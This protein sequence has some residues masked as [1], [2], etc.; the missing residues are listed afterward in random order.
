MAK[1]SAVFVVGVN[2]S[3]LKILSPKAHEEML[4]EKDRLEVEA[5]KRKIREKK[6]EEKKKMKEIEKAKKILEEA[7]L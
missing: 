2:K 6:S 4:K 3:C 7:G 1:D 5:K